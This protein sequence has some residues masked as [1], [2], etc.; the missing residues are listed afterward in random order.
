MRF[1]LTLCIAFFFE[2]AYAEPPPHIPDY[3]QV[4][5]WKAARRFCRQYARECMLRKIEAPVPLAPEKLAELDEVNR[6]VNRTVRYMT[7]EEHHG[8]KDWW[9]YPKD[10]TGDCEDYVL[11]KRRILQRKGWPRSSLLI[12][13]AINRKGT[14]HAVL[15]VRTDGGDLILDDGRDAIQLWHETPYHF[16]MRES[17]DDP[18]RWVSAVP[19]PL[20]DEA[21]LRL[22]T[23]K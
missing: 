16:V 2:N 17:E 12:A 10:G 5:G 13:V 6:L 23:G 1:V 21:I 15:V 7:D 11:R 8:I 22:Y 18:K 14:G 4:E 19:L 3:G 9:T 20:Q